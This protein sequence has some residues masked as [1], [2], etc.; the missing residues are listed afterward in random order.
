[1]FIRWAWISSGALLPGIIG[2][3]KDCYLFL[4]INGAGLGH[5]SRAL[6]V[7]KE[8]RTQKPEAHIVFLTTS[9]AVHLV[10]REG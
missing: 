7:A 5:V 10:Y 6:A 1:R 2:L 9:I 4:P 3:K 8:L